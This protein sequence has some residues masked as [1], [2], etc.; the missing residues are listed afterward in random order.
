MTSDTVSSCSNCHAD[1]GYG[2]SVY[3]SACLRADS[4]EFVQRR[5]DWEA[6][7]EKN[8]EKFHTDKAREGVTRRYEL[9]V[10]TLVEMLSF[11]LCKGTPEFIAF[12]SKGRPFGY[13]EP[14]IL[15]VR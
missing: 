14:Y 11:P 2:Q 3:C 15:I 13:P 9:K 10:I 1:R 12:D 4:L 7:H 6:A 5:L 8:E